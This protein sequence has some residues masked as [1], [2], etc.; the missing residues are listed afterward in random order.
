MATTPEDALPPWQNAMGFMLWRAQV[1]VHRRLQ[2]SVGELGVS[3]TQLGL[4]VHLHEL[5]PLSASDLSRGYRIT[6]QSVTTNLNSLVDAG[7][8][9]RRPHPAHGRVLLNELSEKGVAGVLRGREIVAAQT[10]EIEALL[11]EGQADVLVGM[12]TKIAAG[13][14]GSQATV[15]MLWPLPRD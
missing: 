4:A 2:E 7:W 1:A 8:V 12:L 13:I 3:M 6:P 5:G 9:T 15:G 11:P 10:R 14:D